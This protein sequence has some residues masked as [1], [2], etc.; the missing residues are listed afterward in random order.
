MDFSPKEITLEWTLHKK[1]A[2]A[3][4]NTTQF[5][6]SITN[7]PS[8][9]DQLFWKP[10]IVERLSELSIF[11]FQKEINYYLDLASMRERYGKYFA[12]GI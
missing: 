9:H 6:N 10:F 2:K 12:Y 8:F 5:L 3:H 11:P 4:I 7:T 1:H